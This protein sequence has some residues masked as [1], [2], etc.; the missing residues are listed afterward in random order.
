MT[1]SYG[2]GWNGN[3]LSIKQGSLNYLFGSAFTSGSTFGPQTII[4]NGNLEAS[5]Q[6]YSL[7]LKTQ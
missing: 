3:I 5:I 2:D 6:V 1:D 4:I 7:G